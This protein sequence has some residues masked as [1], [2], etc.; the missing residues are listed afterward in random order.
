MTWTGVVRVAATGL[1]LFGLVRFGLTSSARA[2][3]SLATDIKAAYLYKFAPFV[4]W[5]GP[6]PAADAPFAVCVVG[7]DPFGSVLDRAVAGQKVG[8]RPIIVRRLAAAARDM[9]C[10]IAFLAGG[11]GQGVKDEL[12]ALHGAP[13][14]TVTD[15]GAAAGVVDFAIAQGRVRFRIDDETAAEDGLTI[16]SKLLSL[17]VSVRPRKTSGATP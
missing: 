11:R 3:E 8:A 12:A 13:V 16:S 15:G 14:L 17:A 9:P 5:P 6:P 2:Q 1:V 7:A 10:Q 4:V